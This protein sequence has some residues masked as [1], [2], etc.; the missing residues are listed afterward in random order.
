MTEM[1]KEIEAPKCDYSCGQDATVQLEDVGLCDECA[2]KEI[3]KALEP[4]FGKR[5]CSV[6]RQENGFLQTCLAPYGVEHDH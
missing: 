5:C 4:S 6:S 3:R 2:A 1:D